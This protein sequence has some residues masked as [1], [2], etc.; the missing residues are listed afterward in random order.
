MAGASPYQAMTLICPT[1]VRSESTFWRRCC[2]W[3][4]LRGKNRR[5]AVGFALQALFEAPPHPF[6]AFGL[7]CQFNLLQG[8]FPLHRS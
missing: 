4:W 6:A 8:E 5:V 2:A 1:P 7:D 3:R